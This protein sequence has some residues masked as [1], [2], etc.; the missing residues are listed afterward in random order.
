MPKIELV[1][2]QQGEFSGYYFVCPGCG[3]GH[4]FDNRWT[5]NNDYEKPSF[6]PSLLVNQNYPA[7]RCHSFVTDGKI[8]FLDDCWH[9]LRGLEVDL[10]EVDII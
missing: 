10:P 8:K 6:T 2:N 9:E 7:S 3:Y 4:L 5:F 1:K